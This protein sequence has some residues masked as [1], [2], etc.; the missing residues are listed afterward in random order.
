MF[1]AERERQAGVTIQN[2][3]HVSSIL[4]S[5]L[6]LYVRHE[7]SAAVRAIILHCL[8][9]A[10]REVEMLEYADSALA[11]SLYNH[12]GVAVHTATHWLLPNTLEDAYD[13]FRVD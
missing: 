11:Q 10:S 8:H 6:S 3:H 1:D 9:E 13:I 7:I 4:L 12:S 5:L 2:S